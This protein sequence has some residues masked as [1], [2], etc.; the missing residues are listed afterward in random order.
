[1]WTCS[2]TRQTSP[3]LTRLERA[4]LQSDDSVVPYVRRGRVATTAAVFMRSTDD[5]GIANRSP[6]PTPRTRRK[7]EVPA[8]SY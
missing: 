6:V 4:S 5:S 2:V 7:R 3:S 8:A 1:M